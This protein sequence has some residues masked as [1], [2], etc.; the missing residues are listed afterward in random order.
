[1]DPSDASK[2]LGAIE[3]R[4][5]EGDEPL[6]SQGRVVGATL[7]D[8]W[9]WSCSDLSS[10]ATR[11]VL[12]EFIVAHALR[13]VRD[14]RVEWD[15]VDLCTPDGITVEVKSS[16]FVQSWAQ[17]RLSTPT[18]GIRPTRRWS[19]ERR[20]WEEA[21]QRQAD[22]Y[23]FALFDHRKGNVSTATEP[24]DPLDVSLW[25]F[26]VLA[27][28]TIDDELGSQESVGWRRLVGLGAIETRF[29]GLEGAVRGVL[30]RTA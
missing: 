17:E 2:L 13:A 24:P 22:V 26:R 4:R 16:A 6:H 3:P 11:G 5:R 1:M 29:E 9:R 21:R 28:R 15:A 12:A 18:F 25:T 8:F 27:T 30:A 20:R 19:E 7:L 23:V 14:V 10:N